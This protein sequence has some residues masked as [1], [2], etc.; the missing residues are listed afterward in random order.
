MFPVCVSLL[1]TVLFVKDEVSFFI[2]ATND[3]MSA[4]VRRSGCPGY[5]VA[6]HGRIS[7][8]EWFSFSGAVRYQHDLWLALF[9]MFLHW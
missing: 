3:S 8:G 6:S 5:K 9:Y 1:K 2:M 7:G 4:N